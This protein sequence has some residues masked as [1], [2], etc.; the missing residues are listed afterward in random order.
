MQFSATI[1][2]TAVVV[3]YLGT[4]EQTRDYVHCE[5]VAEANILSLSSPDGIYNI[6]TSVETSVNSIV[7]NLKQFSE[8]DF[9][10]EYLPMRLGEVERISLDNSFAA[11]ELNW[12]PKINFYDGIKKTWDW[13][14]E[15]K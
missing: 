15:N 14:S 10:V 8:I 6:G 12:S 13:F 4:G 11:R 9:N 7:E 1:F 2:L 5:D 3:K